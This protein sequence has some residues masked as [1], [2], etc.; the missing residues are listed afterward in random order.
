MAVT[1]PR[2]AKH[3]GEPLEPPA[4][5]LP[6]G[7][8]DIGDDSPASDKVVE[9]LPRRCEAVHTAKK[10]IQGGGRGGGLYRLCA[11]NGHW[12]FGQVPT[13]SDASPTELPSSIR[14]ATTATIAPPRR[15]SDPFTQVGTVG[16]RYEI[17]QD[18]RRV[19]PGSK[20]QPRMRGMPDKTTEQEASQ[21]EATVRGLTRR[22]VLAAAPAASAFGDPLLA[23]RP[24]R[25]GQLT[26]D[27]NVEITGRDLR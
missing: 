9:E 4:K 18:E 27:G 7:I 26:E 24:A 12:N 23:S 17:A 1:S 6:S 19:D 22:T 13:A 14:Q 16:A 21:R 8:S 10:F 3:V 5:R 15:P 2:S 25:A 20:R 11:A